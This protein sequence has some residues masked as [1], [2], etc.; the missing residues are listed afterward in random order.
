MRGQAQ[1]KSNLR[2]KFEEEVGLLR[3]RRAR[4]PGRADRDPHPAHGIQAKKC[5]LEGIRAVCAA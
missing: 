3:E 1:D 4:L 5:Q 2:W